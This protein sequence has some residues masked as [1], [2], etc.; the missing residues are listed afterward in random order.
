LLDSQTDDPYRES[1][2]RWECL[3]HEAVPGDGGTMYL[4]RRGDEYVIEVD[5]RELMS[6][7]MHGSEDALAN[8]ACDRLA[9]LDDA[10]ILVGGLGMGFTLAAAL[11]RAGASGNVTVAELVPAVVRWNEKYVGASSRYP[12]QDSRTTL[13][14]GD[15]GDL[16]ETPPLSWSAILLDVDNG[17]SALTHPDNDWL[18]T[19]DGLLAANAALIRGGVLAIWSATADDS[20]T[21]RL[22]AAGFDTEVLHFTEDAR[23][24]CDETGTHVLWMARSR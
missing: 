21:K 24:T 16:L 17:P 3:D 23:P 22:R 1:T 13:Y 5:G 6:N 4:M 12:L 11:D 19:T 9:R 7:G 15:V 8:F 14:V 20:F 2:G 10:R 18:Y